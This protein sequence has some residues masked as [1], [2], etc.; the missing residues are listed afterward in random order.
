MKKEEQN[1]GNLFGHAK[2][3]YDVAVKTRNS[4]ILMVLS[5]ANGINKIKTY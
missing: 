3:V 5:S 4:Y 2:Q 1:I